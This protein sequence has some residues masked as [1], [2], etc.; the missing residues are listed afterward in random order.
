MWNVTFLGVDFYHI[1]NWLIIYSFLGWV[2]ETV[3]VS[4]KQGQYVNRGFIDGPLCTIYGFGAVSVYLLLRPLE[5]NTFILYAGGIVVAT[6]LE[7][8]TALLMESIFHTSWWDYS[9]DRFNF[10][11]R[12]CLRASLAWGGFTVIL[13]RVL[14]PMVEYVVSLYPRI[15]GQWSVCVIGV[16]YIFDFSTSAAA[17][18]HLRERIPVWEEAV[19]KR[20][21]EL[22]LAAGEKMEEWSRNHGVSLS[23][24]RSRIENLE[25]V[26][27]FEAKRQVVMEEMRR[28]LLKYKHS[29]T[30]GAERSAR[31]FVKA[32]PN[33]DRGYRLRHKKT[34]KKNCKY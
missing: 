12:I 16:V 34:E 33:L 14:H 13:F 27:A 6:V 5:A 11:G 18:F 19:E 3:Y 9:K 23:D 31:R 29:I 22:M 4:I 8:F 10:Q 15:A 21:A 2:W 25:L 24:M 20:R 1:A 30:S 32:Y 26:D 28:E 17:A 7:Y